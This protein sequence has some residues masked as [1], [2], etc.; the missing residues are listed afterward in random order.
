MAAETQDEAAHLF[1]S[2]ELWRLGRD[3]GV[4]SA[5]PSPEEAVAYA[6]SAGEQARI[7]RLREWALYGTPDMVAGKLRTLAT[8]H[9]VEEIA[10]L[11]TLHDPEARRRSYMLLA[12]EFGLRTPE[13][14]L[15]AQ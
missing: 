2:R 3:R 15:A 10:I 7:E 5:L 9:Q 1:R 11:T 12:R 13:V 6:Y 14:R 8:A 4:Y